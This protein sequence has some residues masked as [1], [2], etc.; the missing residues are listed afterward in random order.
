[1]LP[2]IPATPTQ[3][4]SFI[5]RQQSSLLSTEFS[6]AIFHDGIRLRSKHLRA[7]IFLKGRAREP[8]TT[9]LSDTGPRGAAYQNNTHLCV[10]ICAFEASLKEHSTIL[11]CLFILSKLTNHGKNYTACKTVVCLGYSVLGM[12]HTC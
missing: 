8:N 11:T 1:M 9:S 10:Q 4:L 3:Q 5:Q 6:S 7:Q 12:A 2:H